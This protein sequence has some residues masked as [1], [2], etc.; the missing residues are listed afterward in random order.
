MLMHGGYIR[1]DW[2]EDGDDIIQSFDRD[3]R[4]VENSSFGFKGQG[5]AFAFSM[6]K[7][8]TAKVGPW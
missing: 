3:R 7:A 1:A 8:V 4:D 2:E 6:A 5:L